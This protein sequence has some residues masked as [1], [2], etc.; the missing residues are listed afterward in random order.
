MAAHKVWLVIASGGLAATILFAT[1]ES[2]AKKYT[3]YKEYA[4]FVAGYRYNPAD[5]VWGFC[6]DGKT[7]TGV[8]N[9]AIQNFINKGGKK[10]KKIWTW[11]CKGYYAVAE[12][13]KRG[14]LG[15]KACAVT[16]QGAKDQATDACYDGGG[17]NCVILA[18]GSDHV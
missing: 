14:A 13:N 5:P 15:L 8:E 1:H 7:E 18:S 4:S 2:G 17:K 16:L 10:A 9:C 12:D 6:T 3:K 11:S